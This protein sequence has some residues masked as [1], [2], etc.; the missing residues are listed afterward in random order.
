MRIP[1]WL[2][3]VQIVHRLGSYGDLL[4]VVEGPISIFL[5]HLS[6]NTLYM[7]DALEDLRASGQ[8]VLKE[9]IERLSPL[10]LQHVNLHG[11][12]HLTLP[13]AV[14][15][16]HHRPLRRPPARTGAGRDT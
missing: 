6:S 2:L 13:E 1:L 7:Q 11:R 8:E 16:G 14:V 15:Q 3:T 5:L 4:T 12:Y 10:T 9:D